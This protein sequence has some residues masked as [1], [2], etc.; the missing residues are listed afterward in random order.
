MQ[1]GTLRTALTVIANA[2][3]GMWIFRGGWEHI[4]NPDPD[5]FALSTIDPLLRLLAPASRLA[6]QAHQPVGGAVAAPVFA[7]GQLGA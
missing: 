6:E 5:V 3:R 4:Y 1:N 2:R 7:G